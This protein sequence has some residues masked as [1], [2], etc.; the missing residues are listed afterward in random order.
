MVAAFLISSQDKPKKKPEA[1]D[2]QKLAGQM[3]KCSQLDMGGD[4]GAW[5]EAKGMA[6]AC[7]GQIKLS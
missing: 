3:Q 7:S 6:Q 1:E 2:L 5:E 4:I